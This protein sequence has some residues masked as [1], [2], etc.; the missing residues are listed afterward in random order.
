MGHV[1]L[2]WVMQGRVAWVLQGWGGSYRG[3]WVIVG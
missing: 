1:G 3:G 2:G